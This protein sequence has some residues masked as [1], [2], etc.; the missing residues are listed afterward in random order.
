[1]IHIFYVKLMIEYY[2]YRISQ[3]HMLKKDSGAA[4]FDGYYMKTDKVGL[5]D[6]CD[7]Y[8]HYRFYAKTIRKQVKVNQGMKKINKSYQ[9]KADII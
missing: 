1:M 3:Y 5:H 7:F 4:R 9:F 2:S 6:P 8:N